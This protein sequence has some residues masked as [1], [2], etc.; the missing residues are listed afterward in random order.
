MGP[1]GVAVEWGVLVVI[2]LELWLVR[3]AAPAA[4]RL[5]AAV[6]RTTATKHIGRDRDSRDV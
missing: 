1:R 6:D 3:H 2:A 4:G 5:A